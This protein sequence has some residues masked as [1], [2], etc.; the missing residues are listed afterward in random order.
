MKKEA[1]CKKVREVLTQIRLYL[2]AILLLCK[3]HQE[4]N[5]LAWDTFWQDTLT[6]S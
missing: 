1:A 3:E 6:L 5:T 2:N 4:N